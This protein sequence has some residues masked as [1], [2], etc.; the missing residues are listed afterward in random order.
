MKQ[1]TAE[2][3]PRETRQLYKY[4]LLQQM[5][6]GMQAIASSDNQLPERTIE[7]AQGPALRSNWTFSRKRTTLCRVIH[8]GPGT[9][10]GRRFFLGSAPSS[11]TRRQDGRPMTS[12]N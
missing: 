6:K 8:S 2:A 11:T 9:F 5:T 1:A 7:N 10:R 4:A 3:S 12:V